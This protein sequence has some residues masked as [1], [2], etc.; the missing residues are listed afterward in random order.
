MLENEKLDYNK[1]IEIV[2]IIS[3]NDKGSVEEIEK[4]VNDTEVYYDT[5]K[6]EFEQDRAIF[7]CND[8]DTI[9]WIGMVNNLIRHGYACELD[10]KEDLDEF[11]ASLSKIKKGNL[12]DYSKLD[13][14]DNI[15]VWCDKINK[16]LKKCN[17]GISCIDIDSDSYVLFICELDEIKKIEILAKDINHKI[18][19]QISTIP[20]KTKKKNKTKNLGQFS[21][22]FTIIVLI[23]IILYI[24]LQKQIKKSN[25]NS[26]K[27]YDVPDVNINIYPD[28]NY[29]IN[30]IDENTV[31]EIFDI[32]KPLNF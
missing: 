6:S 9:I 19:L 13:K 26:L 8:K 31:N 1:C 27:K 7:D 17:L 20:Q 11:K 23:C 25:N 28:I 22:I 12:I 5:V 15:E 2:K 24:I 10:W 3:K 32:Q 29:D 21:L 4:C 30:Q 14:N 16:A 18:N